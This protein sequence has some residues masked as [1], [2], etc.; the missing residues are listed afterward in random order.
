ML[1]KK[2]QKE[3]F[4]WNERVLGSNLNTY[5]EIKSTRKGNYIGKY[6]KAV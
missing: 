3:S 4:R 5:E 6:K 1:F 2:Y